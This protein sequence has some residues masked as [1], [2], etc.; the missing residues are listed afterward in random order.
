[1]SPIYKNW[2]CLNWI[3]E[4]DLADKRV[5]GHCKATAK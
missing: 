3:D 2:I 1:M 5:R 4:L